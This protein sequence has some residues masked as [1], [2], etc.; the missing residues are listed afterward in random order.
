MFILGDCSAFLLSFVLMCYFSK[1]RQSRFVKV[2]TIT[3]S[4]SGKRNRSIRTVRKLLLILLYVQG[5]CEVQAR[6]WAGSLSGD[7]AHHDMRTP[8]F[9]DISLMAVGG[10][11]T[12]QDDNVFAPPAIFRL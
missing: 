2:G 5:T 4:R 6:Q 7:D 3:V 11:G 9:D 12:Y 8:H 1:K 10:D